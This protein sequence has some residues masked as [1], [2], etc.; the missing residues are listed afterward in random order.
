VEWHP[1]TC[2][3]DGGGQIRLITAPVSYE[4]LVQRSFEKIRQ[5]AGGMPAVL[6]R[7]LDAL[8]KIMAVA[9]ASRTQVLLD[10]AIMIQRVNL[11]TVSEQADQTDITA[12]YDALLALHAQVTRAQP[13]RRPGN[14]RITKD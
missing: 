12:R 11:R 3:R 4:R 8:S 10:Q 7:Q 5:A 2:H 1:D 13:D 9:P 14:G 6:I